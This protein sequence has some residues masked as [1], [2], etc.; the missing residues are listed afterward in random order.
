MWSS[1][2][3]ARAALEV[4]FE[5][6]GARMAVDRRLDRLL[7]QQGAAEIGVQHGAGG[8]D[9]RPQPLGWVSTAIRP[10]TSAAS[11]IEAGR[12][13]APGAMAARAAATASRSA[14]RTIVREAVRIIACAAPPCSSRSTGGRPRN[15]SCKPSSSVPT[16]APTRYP[17]SRQERRSKTTSVNAMPAERSRAPDPND[18]RLQKA[19]SDSRPSADR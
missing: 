2:V 13:R 12:G 9:R 7:G 19:A 11:R 4:V 18:R 15:F 3:A 8:I 17:P 6:A 5:V 1:R 10:A 14:S 16:P